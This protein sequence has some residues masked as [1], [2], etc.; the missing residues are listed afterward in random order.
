MEEIGVQALALAGTMR[1]RI[2]GD[3]HLGQV[4]IAQN[5]VYL[6]DF[7]GEPARSLEQRRGKSCPWR[8]VAGLLRSFDYAC[9]AFL[10]SDATAEPASAD[11]ALADGPG[12]IGRASGR[13]KGW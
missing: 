12:Q 5:D 6:I 7:E 8:D 2:H 4:L 1:T 13:G 9:A 3:F 10:V 11:S